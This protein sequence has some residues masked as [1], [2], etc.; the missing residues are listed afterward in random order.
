[1]YFKANSSRTIMLFTRENKPAQIGN[2]SAELHE[3][4]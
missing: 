3:E 1:M 4:L 2:I